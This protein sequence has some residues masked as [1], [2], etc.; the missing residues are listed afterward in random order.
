MKKNI[1]FIGSKILDYKDN[2][3]I[4]NVGGKFNK[5]TKYPVW[6][7]VGEKDIGQ[8]DNKEIKVD[9][10]IG[11]S[12]FLHKSLIQRIGL[13]PE[14]YFLYYEDTDW[15]LT[16]Q[17]AGFWNSTCAKSIVYHKQGI[18][19]EVKHLNNDKQLQNKKY[20]Y[21]GYLMLYHRHFKWLLP[22]AYLI[23]FKQM[24]GKAWHKKYNEVSMIFKTLTGFRNQE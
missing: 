10:V 18:S 8:F 21:W 16:A 24:A 23:L 7:G 15:C 2:G 20:L 5:W 19:T 13:M 22:I 11:A 3:L 6:I 4:Q 17:K 1:G 9:H 12:M 14:N